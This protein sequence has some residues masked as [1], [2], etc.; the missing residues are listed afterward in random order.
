MNVYIGNWNEVHSAYQVARLGTVS[1][2]AKFLGVHHATVI[3]HVTALERKLGARLFF[4]H[5]RGYTPTPAGQQLLRVAAATEDQFRQLATRVRGQS[6]EV[7]GELT[8]T[9]I[10]AL[11][12]A[13]MA[14][15]AGFQRKFPDVRVRLIVDERRLKLEY[16]EAH[17]AI[18]AGAKP[19]EPDNV[20]Q[21]FFSTNI[22][23]YA[24]R[25]YVERA[26]TPEHRSDIPRHRFLFPTG[27]P[28]DSPIAEWI[29]RNVPAEAIAFRSPQTRAVEDALFA[30]MGIA[31]QTDFSV[32]NRPE[33]VPVM[34]PEPQ[35]NADFWLVTHVDMHRTAN[36]QACLGF[37]KA[38]SRQ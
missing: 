31:A 14:P 13:L 10:D 28:G 19:L 35:W 2:A 25:D 5:P 26:G 20:V 36:V 37:L 34:R 38:W 15:L 21:H 22:A 4:R 8:I 6:A 3:R 29:A 33:I 23:F 16:G 18:R 30:G 12:R 32:R 1:A 27:L 11:S 24:H 9:T 7:S 17:I